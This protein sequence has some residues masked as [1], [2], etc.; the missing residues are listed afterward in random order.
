MSESGTGDNEWW[1]SVF[2]A[3]LHHMYRL[4]YGSALGCGG[5]ACFIVASAWVSVRLAWVLMTLFE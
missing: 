3:S 4:G 1:K 5:M 2:P